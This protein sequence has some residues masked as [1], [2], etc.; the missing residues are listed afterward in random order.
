[1]NRNTEERA[2]HAENQVADLEMKLKEA[3]ERIR[4]LEKK[5]PPI[6]SSTTPTTPPHLE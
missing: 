1:M 6:N 4:A 3:M 2:Q 5:T